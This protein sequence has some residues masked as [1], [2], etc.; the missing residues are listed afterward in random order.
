MTNAAVTE[1]ISYLRGRGWNAARIAERL[2]VPIEIVM[3]RNPTTKDKGMLA[4][5]Q[6]ARREAH[7]VYTRTCPQ[8]GR[9]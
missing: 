6:A 7:L 2:A 4:A 9:T 5:G 8:Y 1:E 3:A